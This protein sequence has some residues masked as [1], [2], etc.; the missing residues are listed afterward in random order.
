MIH[1]THPFHGVAL[2]AALYFTNTTSMQTAVLVGG[3]AA[4]YMMNYGHSLPF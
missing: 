1:T 2:G 3:A 4:L